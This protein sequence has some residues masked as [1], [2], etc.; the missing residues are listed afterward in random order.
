MNCALDRFEEMLTEAE[1]C[2][3][4]PHL[5]SERELRTARQRGGIPFISGKKGVVLY[6]PD[7]VAEYFERKESLCRNGYGNM[8]ATGSVAP[9]IPQGSMPTGMTGE[10]AQLVAGHLAQK[11]SSKRK[12]S[13]SHSLDQPSVTEANLRIVS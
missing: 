12:T 4:F 7:A 5:V 2:R 10:Q 6:H 11:Y 9:T 8:G 13:S 1:V 3:R